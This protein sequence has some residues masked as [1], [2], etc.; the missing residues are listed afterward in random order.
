VS[1]IETSEAIVVNPAAGDT[2][3]VM[4]DLITFKLRARDTGGA[5]TL[6]EGLV[7][8]GGF[9]PVHFH[10]REDETFYVLEGTVEFLVAGE[11]RESTAG[12]VVHIPRGVVHGFR[13]TSPSIVRLLCL[14]L[15]GGLHE[16]LFA[17]M[18]QVPPPATPE[19]G[20]ALIAL[21]RRY[22]TEILPP[23]LPE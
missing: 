19:D 16:E 9:E 18:S 17:A 8:P 7:G 4:G 11:W 20:A 22:G 13:N 6:F 14:N 10:H 2:V 5:F 3:R 1:A 23:P 12:T 15:P 21:A